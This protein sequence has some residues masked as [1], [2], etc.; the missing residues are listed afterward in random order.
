MRAVLALMALLVGVQAAP[1]EKF[2]Y[3][4]MH[5]ACE[6]L[7]KTQIVGYSICHIDVEA[8][9]KQYLRFKDAAREYRELPQSQQTREA[10]G[11]VLNQS[12]NLGSSYDLLRTRHPYAWAV[13]LRPI[14]KP[15]N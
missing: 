10:L 13:R 2:N 7:K 9:A 8:A 6:D 14:T 12:K 15:A 5:Q 1:A 11:Y 3:E 4:A